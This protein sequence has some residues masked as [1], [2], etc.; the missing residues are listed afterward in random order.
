MDEEQLEEIEEEDNDLLVLEA[1]GVTVEFEHVGTV[2]YEG[3]EYAVLLPVDE[4]VEA[5]AVILKIET[6]DE[7]DDDGE[8]IEQFVDVES[9]ELLNKLFAI[10]MEEHADEFEFVD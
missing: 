3:E 5:E 6:T 1:D 10:F 9:E 2:E 7:F 8:P 4:E